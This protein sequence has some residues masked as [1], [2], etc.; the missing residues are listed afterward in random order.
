M[1]DTIR[2]LICRVA[3]AEGYL[4]DYSDEEGNL[5]IENEKTGERVNVSVKLA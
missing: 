4:T 5:V 1:E 2:E 3:D